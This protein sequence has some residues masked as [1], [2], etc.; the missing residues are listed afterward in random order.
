[1][2]IHEKKFLLKKLLLS[3][4]PVLFIH[5]GI[6]NLQ[7]NNSPIYF[8]SSDLKLISHIYENIN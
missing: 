1:M 4:I 5:T 7:N 8:R 2:K 6:N 3:F